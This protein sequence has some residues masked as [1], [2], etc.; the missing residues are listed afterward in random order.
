MMAQ[1][2]LGKSGDKWRGLFAWG[3]GIGREF[4][5]GTSPRRTGAEAGEVEENAPPKLRVIRNISCGEICG[6]WDALFVPVQRPWPILADESP[7]L[8]TSARLIMCERDPGPAAAPEGMSALPQRKRR[9]FPVT[10]QRVY[11]P[12]SP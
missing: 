12:S 4:G 5:E 3:R 6:L 2:P 1:E 10:A 9:G 8:R 7:L 11:C